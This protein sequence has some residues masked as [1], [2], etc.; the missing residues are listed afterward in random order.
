[1]KIFDN[2]NIESYEIGQLTEKP[3]EYKWITQSGIEDIPVFENDELTK[4]FETY[5]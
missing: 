5:K 1:M 2:H 3:N 4:C